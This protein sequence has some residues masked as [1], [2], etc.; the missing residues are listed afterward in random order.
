MAV[1]T[2]YSVGN[3]SGQN[4]LIQHLVA[5]GFGER[6]LEHKAT[7]TVVVSSYKSLFGKFLNGLPVF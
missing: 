6:L 1:E 5:A 3:Y 7:I 2:S 4:V